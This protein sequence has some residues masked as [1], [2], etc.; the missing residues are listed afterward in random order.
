[1]SITIAE[2]LK[3]P[4][5]HNA[6]VVAGGQ[7]LDRWVSTIS[8]SEYTWNTQFKDMYFDYADS[9][10]VISAF[11]AAKDSVETQLNNIEVYHSNRVAGLILFY[12]GVI[13]PY[14]DERVINLA[15]RLN[16]PIIM[17][18]EGRPDLRYSEVI[19]EVVEAIIKS[20]QHYKNLTNDII[21]Q[22]SCFPASQRS[23][24]SAMRVL[25]NNT[26]STIVLADMSGEPFHV[27]VWPRT[28]NAEG[29]LRDGKVI[30]EGELSPVMGESCRVYVYPIRTAKGLPLQAVIYKR[31]EVFTA[32]V[33]RQI[34]ETIQTAMNLWGRNVGENLLS[35]LV[36]AILRDEPYK[37]RRLSSL[38]SVDVADIKDMWI[39]QAKQ[40]EQTD[41]LFAAVPQLLQDELPRARGSFI[42]DVFEESAAVMFHAVGERDSLSDAA[43]VLLAGLK[44]RGVEAVLTVCR[45]LGA[46]DR[47][48][49]AYTLNESAL[50][51]ARKIFP[52]KSLFTLSELRFADECVKRIEAGEE[53][54]RQSTEMLEAIPKDGGIS[55]EDMLKTLSAYYLD[56]RG[57]AAAA[58]ELLFVHKNTIQYRIKKF[59][60][61][62]ADNL[63]DALEVNELLSALAIERI[64]DSNRNNRL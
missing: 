31:G 57:N 42:Y 63:C 49:R 19:Y 12:V 17:M 60:E 40:P 23:L 56:A 46:A 24:G 36:G 59:H 7:V 9:E 4:S 54:V 1:M 14:L 61:Y 64:L 25:S 18:P 15:D 5:M 41:Q 45:N 22:I 44:E 47:I 53:S 35:E 16:F 37:M 3:L 62:I 10:I 11:Y 21:E 13:L 43:H 34:G 33:V 27:S 52:L 2:I 58:A 39:L 8:V 30:I 55:Y 26:F 48:R 38:F 29:Y 6:R 50:R 32:D 28:V 20:H 51:T